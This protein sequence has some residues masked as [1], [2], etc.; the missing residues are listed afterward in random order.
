[1]CISYTLTG[2]IYI[3]N[4]RTI[5]LRG[6]DAMQGEA[7]KNS[8]QMMQPGSAVGKAAQT[9]LNAFMGL[10]LHVVHTYYIAL[11]MQ[12]SLILQKAT[13]YN[14]PGLKAPWPNVTRLG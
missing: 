11:R 1:M 5:D 4:I 10:M 6:H 13:R 12:Q 14:Q 7:L 8:C 3:W 9:A 2:S